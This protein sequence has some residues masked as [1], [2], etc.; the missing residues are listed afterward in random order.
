MFWSVALSEAACQPFGIADG[1]LGAGRSKNSSLPDLSIFFLQKGNYLGIKTHY[2][3]KFT[4]QPE[5]LFKLFEEGLCLSSAFTSEYLG[6]SDV[7]QH[8]KRTWHILS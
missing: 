3:E 5:F 8:A 7:R 4:K 6:Q 1:L 2:Y